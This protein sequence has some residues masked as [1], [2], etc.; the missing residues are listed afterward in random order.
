V[1]KGSPA[2]TLQGGGI[3]ATNPV[4]QTNSA[5]AKNVPDQCVGC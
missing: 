1:L 4:S 2:I 5:I 3:Y